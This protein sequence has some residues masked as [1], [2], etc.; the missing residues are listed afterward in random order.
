M[1]ILKIQITKELTFAESPKNY[2]YK[3]EVLL[4]NKLEVNHN[5]IERHLKNLNSI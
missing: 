4:E 2:I 1:A 3:Q 5:A